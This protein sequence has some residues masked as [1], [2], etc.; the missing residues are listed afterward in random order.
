MCIRDRAYAILKS[1]QLGFDGYT[2]DDN[3]FP[4]QTKVK[5][6]SMRD[7]LDDWKNTLG[8]LADEFIK[9]RADVEPREIAVCRYCHLDSFCRI[10][11]RK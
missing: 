5:V 8:N 3:I 10:G 7:R 2:E 6:C 1:G 11:E 4:E 9:G